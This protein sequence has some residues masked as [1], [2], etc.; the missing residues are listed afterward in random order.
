MSKQE[1]KKTIKEEFQLQNR[2][3]EYTYSTESLLSLKTEEEEY[4]KE[5]VNSGKNKTKTSIRLQNTTLWK[6]ELISRLAKREDIK[7]YKNFGDIIEMFADSLLGDITKKEVTPGMHLKINEPSSEIIFEQDET[8]KLYKNIHF[9]SRVFMDKN[10]EHKEISL[11]DLTY[12]ENYILRSI[13]LYAF[14]PTL[15]S[16]FELE[17][18]L[19]VASKCAEHKSSFA[20][21][22]INLN[23]SQ[24]SIKFDELYFQFGSN[25]LVRD[26]QILLKHKSGIARLPIKN[27][28]VYEES[29][30]NL[31]KIKNAEKLRRDEVSHSRIYEVERFVKDAKYFTKSIRS[32]L[33]KVGKIKLPAE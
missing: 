27:E 9:L 25:P 19:Y 20:I 18:L 4:I 14:E 28:M 17:L 30:S 2:I 24:T 23:D 10:K 29:K 8:E 26:I 22:F 3:F 13:A 6:L 15:L 1:S 32:L 16:K 12:H 21:D 11:A 33:A 31:D 5:L 7:N